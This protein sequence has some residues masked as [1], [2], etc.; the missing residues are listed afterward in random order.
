MCV[1]V[2]ER[3]IEIRGVTERKR[4]KKKREIDRSIKSE[5][6]RK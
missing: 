6:D 4:E 3:D 1:C 2:R 5:R